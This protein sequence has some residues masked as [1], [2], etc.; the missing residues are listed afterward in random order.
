MPL[1]RVKPKEQVHL[2]AMHWLPVAAANTKGIVVL[3]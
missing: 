3:P 2:P 1:Q